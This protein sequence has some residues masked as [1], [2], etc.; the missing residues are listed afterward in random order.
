M[1]FVVDEVTLLQVFLRVYSS[2]PT[3][4]ILNLPAERKAK[5]LYLKK[6]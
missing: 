3:N 6:S 4:N 1:K 5:Y 2:Y